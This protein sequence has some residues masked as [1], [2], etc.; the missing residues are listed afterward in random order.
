[1][2]YFLLVLF[3][4][5]PFLVIAQAQDI[6]VHGK[7]DGVQVDRSIDATG[8]TIRQVIEGDAMDQGAKQLIVVF[9]NANDAAFEQTI[10]VPEGLPLRAAKTILE[11]YGEEAVDVSPDGIENI[12][13]EKAGEHQDFMRR[14]ALLPTDNAAIDDLRRQALQLIEDGEYEAAKPLFGE[15]RDILSGRIQERQADLERMQ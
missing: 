14:L 5:A 4:T 15:A 10:I 8:L 3:L 13:L 7:T 11:R 1:M 12:L 9:G 2:R 6:D